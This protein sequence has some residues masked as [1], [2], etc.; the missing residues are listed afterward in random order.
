MTCVDDEDSRIG[1]DAGGQY[2]RGHHDKAAMLP[3][4]TPVGNENISK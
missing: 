1:A 3:Q 4:L 2:E